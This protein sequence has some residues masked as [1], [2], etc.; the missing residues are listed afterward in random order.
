MR[1]VLDLATNTDSKNDRTRA[2]TRIFNRRENRKSR[3]QGR[4]RLFSANCL[5]NTK[6]MAA[7]LEIEARGLI[8]SR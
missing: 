7:K 4:N 6:N 3:W 5:G 8:V 2:T 1:A